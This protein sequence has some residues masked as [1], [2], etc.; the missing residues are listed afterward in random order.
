MKACNQPLIIGSLYVYPC[1]PYH[2][3]VW[4]ENGSGRKKL[5]QE[6]NMIFH[7]S[8]MPRHCYIVCL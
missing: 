1:H 3:N 7:S 8:Y 5:V 2:G 6:V 4:F